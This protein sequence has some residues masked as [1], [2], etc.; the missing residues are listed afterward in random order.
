VSPTGNVKVQ[1]KCA[2]G[3][4]PGPS[5]ECEECRKKR[6]QR[7]LLVGSTNDPLEL[8]A[9]RLAEQALAGQRRSNATPARK[10]LQRAFGP[11]EAFDA[12]QAGVEEIL[13]SSGSELEPTV[14]HDMEHRFGQD[15]SKVRIHSDGKAAESARKLNALAYT[16]GHHIVFAADRYNPSYGEGKRL[17]SHELVHVMQQQGSA[18]GT[19]QRAID[20]ACGPLL[21]RN[22]GERVCKEPPS[23][24]KVGNEAHRR[25]QA[26]FVR[27]PDNLVELPIPGAGNVCSESRFE[28]EFSRGKADLVRVVKR[29]EAVQVELGEIKPLNSSGLSLGR[30]RLRAINVI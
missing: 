1:R 15:F 3:G 5:G 7:K 2:C 27:P 12:S 13:A 10:H 4:S 22:Q 29:E 11:V 20:P 19:I 25:I 21:A 24:T 18:R 9:D 26:A 17:L 6:L 23:A 8:E 28:P 16:A 30:A 14:K